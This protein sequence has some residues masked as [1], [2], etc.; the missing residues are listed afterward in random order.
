MPCAIKLLSRKAIRSASMRH[1]AETVP[2]RSAVSTFLRFRN[3]RTIQLSLSF[4]QHVPDV[5]NELPVLMDTV[6]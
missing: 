2:V 5:P 3:D 1:G 6:I 4:L